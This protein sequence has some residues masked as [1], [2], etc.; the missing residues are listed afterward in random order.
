MQDRAG[1]RSIMVDLRAFGA[2]FPKHHIVFLSSIV[3][4]VRLSFAFQLTG[5]KNT[6]LKFIA[7]ARLFFFYKIMLA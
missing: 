7:T 5:V 4:I 6:K 3:G 2:S 1:F